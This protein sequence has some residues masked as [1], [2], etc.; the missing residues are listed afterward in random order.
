MATLKPPPFRRVEADGGGWLQW[1]GKPVRG[2]N[3]WVH[4]SLLG[5][6]P[7]EVRDGPELQCPLR[8]AHFEAMALHARVL[9]TRDAHAERFAAFRAQLPNRA[10]IHQGYKPRFGPEVHDVQSVCRGFLVDAAGEA[11]KTRRV[12]PVPRSDRP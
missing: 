8:G 1:L 4:S 6:A 3:E 12:Q 11:F 2:Y 9:A 10:N 7:E 5:R